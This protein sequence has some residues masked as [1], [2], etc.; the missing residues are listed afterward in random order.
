MGKTWKDAPYRVQI[1]RDPYRAENH[2]CNGDDCDIEMSYF[3]WSSRPSETTR[4]TNTRTY[5]TLNPKY[6]WDNDE[7]FTVGVTRTWNWRT[8]RVTSPGCTY[9]QTDRSRRT[10]WQSPPPRW[11]THM[12]WYGP[13]RAEEVRRLTEAVKDYN[14]NGDV[15]HVDFDH[16]QHRHRSTYYY[17]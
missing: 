15:E 10:W 12:N 11:Y 13:S 1:A 17:W 6:R 5:T 16:E 4:G 8:T 2:Y 9:D 7:P 14:A 3:P